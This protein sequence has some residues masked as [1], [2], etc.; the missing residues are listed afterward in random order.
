MHLLPKEI[1]GGI[2]SG[3]FIKDVRSQG[4]ARWY[5]SSNSAI[6]QSCHS[7][8]DYVNFI[9]RPKVNT[10][11]PQFFSKVIDHQRLLYKDCFPLAFGFV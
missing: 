8:L 7:F 4:G 11:T 2:Y 6:L 5:L 10:I 3:V 9:A 1:G